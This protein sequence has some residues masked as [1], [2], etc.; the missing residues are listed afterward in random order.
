MGHHIS[1]SKQQRNILQLCASEQVTIWLKQLWSVFCTDPFKSL[2]NH[3]E[4]FQIIYKLKNLKYYS[5]DQKAGDGQWARR[6]GD[7][8]GG[9]LPQAWAD[10]DVVNEVFFYVVVED[11]VD[12]DRVTAEVESFFRHELV[13]MLLMKFFSTLLLIMT[14]WLLSAE[15]E[16]FLSSRLV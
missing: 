9:E 11:V 14:G 10:G 5:Q 3:L 16:N 8:W 6:E 4:S 7:R 13:K 12:Y 15:V 2:F 1:P